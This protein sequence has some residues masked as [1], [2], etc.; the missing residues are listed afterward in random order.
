MLI[1]N[2]LHQ[3][4]AQLKKVHSNRLYEGLWEPIDLHLKPLG[5]SVSIKPKGGYFVW[6]KIPITGQQLVEIIREHNLE[7]GVGVGTLFSV[8]QNENQYLVR[9]SFA[10]YDTRTLKIGVDRLKQAILIGIKS[11]GVNKS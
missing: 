3:H 10:H 9:L 2:S 11:N 1:D 6:V 7:V 8:T 4:V 5:C